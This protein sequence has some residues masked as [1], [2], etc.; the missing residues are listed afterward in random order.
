MQ[1]LFI[2]STKT[3]PEVL[4]SPTENIF[5]IKGN[6]MPEDVRAI[7]YPV[8]DWIRTFVGDLLIDSSAYTL[9]NPLVFKLDLV[10]F[11]SSSAKF[12]FDIFTELKR[13][14]KSGIP[15]RIEWYYEH[16]DQEMKDAGLDMSSMSEIEFTLIEKSEE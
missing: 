14:R 3:S 2:Q 12:L 5:H 16:E 9:V 1:K 13:L 7:Y 8:T 15:F 6:S 11:N 10:Y 4:L